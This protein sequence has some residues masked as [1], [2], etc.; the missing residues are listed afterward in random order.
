ML[1]LENEHMSVFVKVPLKIFRLDYSDLTD[2]DGFN[3]KRIS[4]K[5]CVKINNSFDE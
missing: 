4:I 2:A 3:W 1:A 5:Y